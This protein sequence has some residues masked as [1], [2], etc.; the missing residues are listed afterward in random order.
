M[1]TL[2]DLTV[3]FR[4]HPALHHISGQFAKGSLTAVTGPNGAGKS[5]LLK[6]ILALLPVNS[7]SIKVAPNLRCIAYLPQQSEI[8][9]NFPILVRDCILLGYW[10]K[11]GQFGSI[12]SVLMA[13]AEAALDAVGL[14]GFSQRAIGS[15][16]AGQFQRVLFARMLLQDADLILLDEPFNAVDSKTTAELLR[17]IASWHR[18]GRTVIAVLHDHAQ[19]RSYFPQTLL[20]ARNVIAWGDTATVMTDDYLRQAKVMAEAWDENSLLCEVGARAA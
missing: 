20:L 5:T 9:R 1:V 10:Q 17:I 12:S 4:R 19:V 16:S 6:S 14:D 7:G 8:E 2:D 11:V 15:L 18:E 13:R 3:A